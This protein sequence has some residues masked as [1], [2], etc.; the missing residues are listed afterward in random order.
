MI[1]TETMTNSNAKQISRQMRAVRREL[2]DDVKD[3]VRQTRRLTEWRHLVR[4]H[5]WLLLAA[6]VSLGYLLVPVR[7]SGGISATCGMA[8][9]ALA[10]L[11]QGVAG[12][13]V[14]GVVS[15]TMGS[16]AESAIHRPADR[17]EGH[18]NPE[19][20]HR[21]AFSDGE[22]EESHSPP[23]AGLHLGVP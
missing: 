10:S 22:S 19:L 7:P 8:G 21:S 18:E 3:V 15:Y 6:G 11:V 14:R 1:A 17:N 16:L 23:T 13:A 20:D 4:S 5:P 9:R 2:Q 12:T